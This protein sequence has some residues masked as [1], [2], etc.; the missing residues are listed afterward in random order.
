[1]CGYKVPKDTEISVGLWNL[2]HDESIFPDPYIYKPERFLDENG[3]VVPPGHS[4]RKALFPF[5]A[6]RRVCLGE[7]L[8]KNRLFLTV[9]AIVQRY[10]ILPGSDLETRE[11]DPR[12]YE[13]GIVLNPG[14]VNVIMVKRESKI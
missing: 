2:H 11:V 10:K 8:A 6:G 13:N 7:T 5:G 9:I 3:Y 12:E 1:M 4:N 14:P